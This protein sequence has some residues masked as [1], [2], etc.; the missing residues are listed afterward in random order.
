[1]NRRCI[2]PHS[3]LCIV[4][5]LRQNS[6]LGSSELVRTADRMFIVFDAKVSDI[7]YLTGDRSTKVS[8]TP[9]PNICRQDVLRISKRLD[10]SNDS[11]AW[12]FATHDYRERCGVVEGSEEPPKQI[13]PRLDINAFQH[14]I[15]APRVDA[16]I[17]NQLIDESK[18]NHAF[19]FSCRRRNSKPTYC[20]FSTKFTS[21]KACKERYN[22]DHG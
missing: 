21:T 5:E 17:D 18:G 12:Q 2:P 22:R 1:M 9:Y 19:N 4:T 15:D 11:S 13:T 3:L 6:C 16:M 10:A 14:S 20:T 8:Q 7:S